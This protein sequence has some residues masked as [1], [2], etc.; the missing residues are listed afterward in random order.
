MF[1]TA[2]VIVCDDPPAM[3]EAVP[4]DG[5]ETVS[6]PNVG[7][8]ATTQ[9][10]FRVEAVGNVF[11]DL[12]N[13]DTTI[14]SSNTAPVLNVTGS[15]TVQRGT[16]TPT[17][18]TVAAVS[19]ADTPISV[20]VSNAPADTAISA[21]VS[22]SNVVVTARA[23]AS[24]ATTNS[25]RTYPVT[26]TV[27][28]SIGST[29]AGTFN[30]IVQPNPAPT[31]GTYTNQNVTAGKIATAT[32]SAAPADANG[33][34]G[35]TPLTVTP[36][37]LAG[38]GTLSV[39]QTTGVVTATTVSATAT[40]TVPVRVTAQD[41]AGAAIVRGF[42]LVI[43]AA[44]APANDNFASA[45]IVSGNSGTVMGAN[46]NATK[47]AGEPS[48]AGNSGGASVWYQWTAPSSGSAT[49]DTLTSG[50]DTLLAVYTGAAVNSLT[51]IAGNN[52]DPAGGVQSK[53]SFSAVAGTVY[54]IAVDGFNSASVAA[55]GNITLH[56]AIGANNPPE[57]TT[58]G[59]SL[60]YVATTPAAAIDSGIAVTDP[61]STNLTGATV[62]ITG[63]FAGAEDVL[64]FSDQGGIAGSYSAGSGVLTLSGSAT[65]AAY[66]TALRAVTYFNPSATPSTAL[67]TVTFTASDGGLS[68]SSTRTINVSPPPVFYTLTLIVSPVDA[69]LIT[70]NPAPNGQ[71][72]YADG[73]VVT[74]TASAN[75][76]F[77]FGSFSGDA[78]GTNNPVQVTMSG[79]KTVTGN[80]TVN[81][82]V[83]V[84]GTYFGLI[85]S[86]ANPRGTA[87]FDNAG[88]GFLKLAV[89]ATSRFTGTLKY[90]GQTVALR[91]SFGSQPGINATIIIP[92]HGSIA[93]A[94]A[95]GPDE[96]VGTILDS[97]AMSVIQTNR[98][99]F[100]KLTN[101]APQAGKYTLLTQPTAPFLGQAQIPQGFGSGQVTVKTSGML[102][103]VGKLGDGA[104]FGVGSG[105]SKFGTTPLY[106]TAYKKLGSVQGMATFQ[107]I[108][109]QSDGDGVLNWFKPPRSSDPLYPA[110]FTTQL[111]YLVSRFLAPARGQRVLILP[112]A[113]GNLRITLAGGNVAPIAP[114]N[115]TLDRNNR[116]IGN[117]GVGFKMSVKSKTGAF[118]GSF[119]DQSTF[120]TRKFS[121]SIFQKQNVGTA[122]FKGA[123]QTG[124][125]LLESSSAPI[126]APDDAEPQ[127]AP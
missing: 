58:I 69:G 111:N 19:D 106:S 72:K 122:A 89:T 46:V 12:S 83:P 107:S 42:N 45:Q 100:N 126:V 92:H 30:L 54:R 105:L 37:T 114:F 120:T 88:A 32:P 118:K 101:P 94:L 27:T 98:N 115:I 65:V 48:H 96:I 35:A 103:V 63:N 104:K 124:T 56:Y 24:I 34:L 99:V 16:P 17:I 102:K 90:A 86:S 44:V 39:N 21:N 43:A 26:L 11:F 62:A 116:V 15:V 51:P 125:V 25:S 74:L 64:A 123:A 66:Q 6:I 61:D 127:D 13:A 119:T 33:N 71:G 67:R 75:S 2:H 80:F 3:V 5:S 10:R 60:A 93:I 87:G 31:L 59:G 7:N 1:A 70:P 18:A 109:N 23:D 81:P 38:G 82:I 49:F 22:G 29:T 84:A 53:V 73:T 8:V 113:T 14:T 4:N 36:T 76:G 68:G 95:G 97:G 91:G 79:D 112:D 9:G 41:T 77:T 40:G 108:A 52:D 47:Q 85:E 28:D 110:G 78:S 121:G 117:G 20:A 50:F 57:V 55:M